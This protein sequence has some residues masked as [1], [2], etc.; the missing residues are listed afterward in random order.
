MRHPA[1]MGPALILLRPG[2]LWVGI[3]DLPFEAST[4]GM[5]SHHPGPIH[6]PTGW[7]VIALLV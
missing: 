4:E 6:N 5:G 3:D 2:V 1:E 7:P